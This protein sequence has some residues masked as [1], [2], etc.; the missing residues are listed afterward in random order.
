MNK[1]YELWIDLPTYVRNVK[2]YLNF[3]DCEV[4]S[5]EEIPLPSNS[6]IDKKELFNNGE[7]KR[8]KV[9]AEFSIPRKDVRG[10]LESILNCNLVL[11]SDKKMGV[12][13]AN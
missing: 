5:L 10:Y 3:G 1:N 13:N 9:F 8:W 12:A 6:N 7:F 2:S 4:I 11:C